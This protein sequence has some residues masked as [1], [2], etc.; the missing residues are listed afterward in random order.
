[1]PTLIC[2]LCAHSFKA[3]ATDGMTVANC[4]RCDFSIPIPGTIQEDFHDRFAKWF[5]RIGAVVILIVVLSV[6]LLATLK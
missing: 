6:S 3:T 1:M 2:P 4:P 5:S